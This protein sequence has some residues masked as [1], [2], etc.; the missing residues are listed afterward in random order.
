MK[1]MTGPVLLAGCLLF[2]AGC[3]TLAGQPG[4][5]GAAI[6]P[7]TLKPGDAAVVT[8]TIRDRQGIIERV[9]GVVVEDPRI[10][11]RL[12]DDGLDPDAKAGDGVWSM[13]VDVPFQAPPGEYFLEMTAY[14]DNGEPVTIR[15]KGGTLK[16]LQAVVPLRILPP[17]K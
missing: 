9:Q 12:M 2:L 3:N 14:T 4:L 5:R 11:F 17:E 1:R 16:P 10:T 15:E 7:D 6:T 8:M 13:A